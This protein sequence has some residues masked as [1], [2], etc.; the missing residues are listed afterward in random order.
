MPPR[1]STVEWVDASIAD[2]ERLRAVP[3]PHGSSQ[4]GRLQLTQ[5][6][7]PGAA[8]FTGWL[9]CDACGQRLRQLYGERAQ[10][11]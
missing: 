9:V 10:N 4:S 2:G 8:M 3:C 11:P 1:E 7:K 5:P 6:Y